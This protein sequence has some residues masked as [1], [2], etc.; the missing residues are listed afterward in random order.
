MCR[1]A[2][3]C[4]PADLPQVARALRLADLAARVLARTDLGEYEELWRSEQQPTRSSVTIDA[5]LPPSFREGGVVL[6]A[7]EAM[8]RVLA[9]LKQEALRPVRAVPVRACVCTS[10]PLKRSVAAGCQRGGGRCCW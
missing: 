7:E 2:A 8:P 10:S 1:A 3:L 5:I 4:K 9:F 6:P